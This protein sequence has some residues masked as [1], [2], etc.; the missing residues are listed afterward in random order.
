MAE[1]LEAVTSW[2]SLLV[3]LVVFGLA[4]GVCLRLIVLTYSRGNPHRAEL[5]AE[6]Y[7]VPRWERPLWVAEQLEVALFEGLRHRRKVSA[8]NERIIPSPPE[9]VWNLLVAA[10]GWAKFYANA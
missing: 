3:V 6:L 4:P 2:R 1:L 10:Q 8:H 9:R 5:I 7:A